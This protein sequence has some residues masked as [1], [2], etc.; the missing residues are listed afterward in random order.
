[1][2]NRRELLKG[3]AAAGLGTA[4]PRVAWA[5]G[6]GEARLL[7]LILRGAMDGLHAVPPVGDRDYARLRGDLA[8][9][10]R[11]ETP[12]LD[13]DGPFALH[14]ALAPIH[15]WFAANELAVVHA[16]ALPYRE[17]SHFDAQNLLENGTGRPFGR[18]SGWLN[19]A[20]Q[21]G[22]PAPMAMARAIPLILRGPAEVTSG[23]PLRTWAPDNAF[24]DRVA[25]LYTED[26]EL[27]FALE[28]G[29]QTQAMLEVHREKAMIESG[30]RGDEL[31]RSA[32]VI[33]RMLGAADGPRIAVAES[34][35]WDTHTGQQGVLN[36]QF[37]TLARALTN[38]R[39]GLGDRWSTTAV[40]V[41]T[42]FGRT[43]HPNG[44]GGTDHG[45]GSVAFLA[46]G[47]V[48]G[49]R[50]YGD[51]PGLASRHLLDGRDLAPTSDLR[52]VFK[53]VLAAHLGVA[54]SLLEDTVFPNSRQAVPWTELIRTT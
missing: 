22:D 33:G 48:N 47:A 26:P 7:V 20:V 14:P 25:D 23:N 27:Q 12:A 35:G 50:V 31:A 3:M 24:L 44:T 34:G 15:P 1:M 21:H 45:T 39:A 30:G 53:G 37:D 8:L 6:T 10:N 5:D 51:W 49:G 32:E 36:R 43:A 4:L 2:A 28:Q 40:L 54:D 41:V 46:G 38:L 18:T 19:H 13:L 17:R 11:G 16:T 29:V 52:S 42:E 9:S